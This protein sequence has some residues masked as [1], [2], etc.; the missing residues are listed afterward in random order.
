MTTDIQPKAHVTSARQAET[1]IARRSFDSFPE[2]SPRPARWW[3][4]SVLILSAVI[5]IAI[6][7]PLIMSSLKPELDPSTI[8]DNISAQKIVYETA[9]ANK[10]ISESD[11]AVAKTN[12]TEYF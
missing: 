3:K 1:A 11:V 4:R 12:I 6:T 9:L 5:V 10:I 7:I 8:E 2:D